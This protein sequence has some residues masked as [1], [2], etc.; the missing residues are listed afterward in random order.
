MV[1]PPESRVPTFPG[2]LKFNP[3]MWS[4]PGTGFQALLFVWRWL[5]VAWLGLLVPLV[6]LRVISDA[7]SGLLPGGKV[8]SFPWCAEIQPADMVRGQ[9][10]G[11]K[12]DFYLEFFVRN[13]RSTYLF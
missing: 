12:M 9:D 3:H 2:V 6:S 7:G 5:G 4:G 8:P 11:S 10:R 1:L 13:I